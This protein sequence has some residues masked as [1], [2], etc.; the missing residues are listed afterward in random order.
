MSAK[1][2][3]KNPTTNERKVGPELKKMMEDSKTNA[4]TFSDRSIEE[5]FGL[6]NDQ[7]RELMEQELPGKKYC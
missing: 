3:A 7:L 1:L 6:G 5:S 2:Y 4:G